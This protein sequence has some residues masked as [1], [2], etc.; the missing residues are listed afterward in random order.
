[1]KKFI[2]VSLVGVAGLIFAVCI[3]QTAPVQ[4]T[5]QKAVE[6]VG[7]TTKKGIISASGGRYYLAESGQTPKE[8]DSYAVDLSAYVG[9]TVTVTGQY[10]GDT[11]FVGSIE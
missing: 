7:D 9:K 11:L 6:K 2:L 8:I 4:P 10:S 1:M 3:Q 5:Q